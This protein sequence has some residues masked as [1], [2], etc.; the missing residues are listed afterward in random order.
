MRDDLYSQMR[1]QEGYYWWH[2]GKR[3]LVLRMIEKFF[4]AG[5]KELPVKILDVGCGTGIMLQELRSYGKIWGL[6]NNDK[7][8]QYCRQKKAGDFLLKAD[9]E[10]ELPFKESFFDAI[11]CLDVLEHVQNEELILSEFFRI[12]K[13]DGVLIL[14]VPAYQHLWSYWDRMARHYRRY[15]TRHLEN[16]LK[17]N[18]FKV[19]K[20]TYYYLFALLPAVIFRLF[21]SRRNLTAK[22]CSSDF[23]A[24]PVLLNKFLLLLAGIER[25]LLSVISLPAGL[26][27][28]CLVR[29]EKP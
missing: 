23:I 17:Q 29:K 28:F 12:L 18:S 10:Q 24:L 25:H 26:S 7:A 14:M 6:D 1:E 27:L 19:E 8:L 2:V 3:K 22:S 16:I 13:K 4:P 15:N 9:L 5:E 20:L 11:M 21:K